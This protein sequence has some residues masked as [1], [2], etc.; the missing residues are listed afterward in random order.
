MI[1]ALPWVQGVRT[2]MKRRNLM[3]ALGGAVVAWQAA[4]RAQQSIRPLIGF[5]SPRSPDESSQSCCSVPPRVGRRRLDRGP[6]CF[7]RIPLGAGRLR[8]T[9]DA[10]N[11]ALARPD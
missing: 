5:L 2:G 11:R 9:A 4:G 6:E 3:L 1:E 7:G 10:R 8:Q